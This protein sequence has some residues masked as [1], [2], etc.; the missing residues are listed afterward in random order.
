MYSP[1]KSLIRAALTPGRICSRSSTSREPETWP[2]RQMPAMSA[3]LLSLTITGHPQYTADALADIGDVSIGVN[4][5]Q[6]AL[7][8]VVAQDRGC[9]LLVDLQAAP[10]DL[11]TVIL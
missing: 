1:A 5:A 8:L 7:F 10:E 11:L 3:W 9:L 4:R 6:L 2:L